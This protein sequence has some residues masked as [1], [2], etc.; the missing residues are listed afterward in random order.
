[1]SWF[2]VGGNVGLA[3]GPVVVAPVL[4]A[5]G[6]AG[7]PWLAL[8]ALGMAAFLLAVRRR[9]GA[10]TSAGPAGAAVGDGKR[11]DDWRSFGWLTV[12][13][14]LRSV[15]YFGISSLVALYVIARFGAGQDTGSA[16]LATFL[17]VGAVA[18]LVGGWIA[19]R[20]GRLTAIRLGYA[21]CVPA[22]GLLLVAPGVATA[23][24]AA[25]L[26]GVALYL[27]FSVQTTLGQEYLPNR[28]GTASGVT[29]GLAVSAGGAVTPLLGALA[30]AHGLSWALATLLALPPVALLIS[31]RLDD[32]VAR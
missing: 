30:D 6:V 13:V 5:H 32:T 22:L 31:L 23:V 12:L 16:V 24:A 25:V 10:R 14:I 20:R 9:A 15:L 1:M 4:L 3:L 21:L 7:T 2:A 17:G 27:P 28:I 19:D 11:A 26:L 29:L 18:T 8:P